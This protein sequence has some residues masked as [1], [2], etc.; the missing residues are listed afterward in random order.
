MVDPAIEALGAGPATTPV[1]AVAGCPAL[2]SAEAEV[3][4]AIIGLVA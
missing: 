4:G 1:Y 3:P 2:P